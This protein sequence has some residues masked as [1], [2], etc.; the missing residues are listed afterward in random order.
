METLCKE[1][2]KKSYS[3]LIEEGYTSTYHDEFRFSWNRGHCIVSI[4][5]PNSRR[6][7]D[8]GVFPVI[9]RIEGFKILHSLKKPGTFPS[10]F[11]SG[12]HQNFL[13]SREP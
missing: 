4:Y 8:L 3:S 12:Q 2:F 13:E 5:D 6:D 1:F 11:W 7:S 10:A 9:R